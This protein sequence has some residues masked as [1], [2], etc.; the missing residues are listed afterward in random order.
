M[1]INCSLLSNPWFKYWSLLPYKMAAELWH[2][3]I[4]IVPHPVI[5]PVYTFIFPVKIGQSRDKILYILL[6]FVFYP[7]SHDSSQLTIR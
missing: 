1:F 2:M 6:A 3:I 4:F 7:Y 5:K